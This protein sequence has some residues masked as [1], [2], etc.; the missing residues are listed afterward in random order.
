M[1][2]VLPILLFL[3]TSFFAQAQLNM[4]FVSQ[5]D[6][7]QSI[8][9]IWGYTAPD[10]TEYALVGTNTG[11][12]IVS[13]A[14]PTNPIEVAFVPGVNTTWRDIKT[15]DQFAY[16]TCDSCNEG[17]GV[18][19]L[20]DLPNTVDYY[21]LTDIPLGTIGSCHN[22]YIDEF[23]TAYLAGCGGLNSGGI[24]FLDVATD[25]ANPAYVGL[26]DATYSHDVY[27]AN[28][29]LYSSEVYEGVFSIFDVTDKENVVELG[30]Q[31]TPLNF[32]HNA[33]LSDDGNILFTTDEKADAPVAAYDVSNPSDI[34]YLDEYA[35]FATLGDGVIPHNVHVWENW[36]IVSYYT[37]GCIIIDATHPDNLVEVG[38]FDTYIP[39]STGF[40]GVWG[41]YPY[42]PSGLVLCT[43]RGNGLFVLQ[44]NYVQAG[45]LEGLVT[46]IVTNAAIPGADI[47]LL[48]TVT[49]TNTNAT[50]EFKTGIATG[51]DYQI[52][53]TK[54]GY[55]PAIVPLTLTNGE[56]T[57]VEVE[58]IPDATFAMS[59]TI[60]DA[61][62]NEGIPNAS[63]AIS[64]PDRTYEAIADA[65][66]NFEIPSMY[67]GNYNIYAG[68]WG[69]KTV[70]NN[71]DFLSPVNNTVT[72]PLEEGLEDIFAV[73]LGWTV[74]ITPNDAIGNWERGT[75][76][77]HDLLGFEAVPNQDIDSDAGNFCYLTANNIEP[78]S[79]LLIGATTTLT[80]PV[81][82]LTN[83]IEPLI[84]FNHWFLNVFASDE[85]PGNSNLIVR[86]SNGTDE[87]VVL[88][89][90]TQAD[91]NNLQWSEDIS[92]NVIDFIELSSTMVFSVEVSSDPAPF[93][94]EAAFDNWSVTEG[95][96][97]SA[98][99]LL[100]NGISMDIYPNP[101]ATNFH[102]KY[103]LENSIKSSN[104]NITNTLGQRMDQIKIEGHTG[105]IR[106]G[107][108]YP[109]GVYFVQLE[110]GEKKSKV[111][112]MVKN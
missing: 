66:G 22:I 10:G 97:V 80:S 71:L 73:D 107:T 8:N 47:N 87:V 109:N 41:A 2:K 35:P 91:N 11:T 99:N 48:N 77:P 25:P 74:S 43:D 51:G 15:W 50:G 104:I 68:S 112:K 38:N 95:Y 59:G 70:E 14:D 7:T 28:N 21:F 58:L 82:D 44:P 26:G 30:S 57:T 85:S 27:V 93:V 42:L 61:L 1:K 49:F 86:L 90:G 89:T 46:D 63:V 9:D 88:E 39:V 5:F 106:F 56:I 4:E 55:F 40:Q 32:T 102:L 110:N 103:E 53:V 54:D 67:I 92:I 101:T 98:D 13:L 31:S 17:L 96:S 29:L 72:I 83:Y 81:F 45:Y 108:D 111:M 105:I 33:W 79:A 23:G 78:D 18:I 12:S 24:V 65:A 37:D 76:K 19:D 36:L 64:N 3:C 94:T 34:Q 52:E 16:V 84:N 60:V 75:P 6:Y 69:Y 100:D 20:S 62:T